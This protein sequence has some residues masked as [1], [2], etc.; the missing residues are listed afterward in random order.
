MDVRCFRCI[1]TQ[2]ASCPEDWLGA[3]RV[4]E[5]AGEGAMDPDVRATKKACNSS[6]MTILA[7]IALLRRECYVYYLFLP[8]GNLHCS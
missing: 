1:P 7:P 2:E 5:D 8:H 3:V 6:T 4:P